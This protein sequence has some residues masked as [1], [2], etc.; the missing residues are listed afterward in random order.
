[1]AR[2]LRRPASS[3]SVETCIPPVQTGQTAHRKRLCEPRARR[4]AVD[5][6]R[7]ITPAARQYVLFPNGFR[8][9]SGRFYA[10]TLHLLVKQLAMNIEPAGRL[11]AVAAGCI[12][13]AADHRC[14]QPGDRCW[15]VASK[16]VS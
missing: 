8:P 15:Q 5:S 12:Q 16:E 3:I 1:M 10:V 13:R 9:I 4:H 14:L 7:I 2:S 6:A 11:G